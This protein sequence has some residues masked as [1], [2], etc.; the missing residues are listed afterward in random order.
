M[1]HPLI[2]PNQVRHNT[3]GFWDNPYDPNR[4]LQIEID[5]TLVIPLSQDGTKLVFE[6]R[7]PTNHEL[8]HFPHM[9]MT[10]SEPWDPRTVK[11]ASLTGGT[12][13]VMELYGGTC[14]FGPIV[15]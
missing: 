8:Q 4:G 12:H 7:V 9:D 5:D 13:D 11:L 1:N 10:Q 14:I 15:G 6:S 3:I 2:N